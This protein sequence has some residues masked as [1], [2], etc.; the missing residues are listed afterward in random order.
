MQFA[1]SEFFKP[2]NYVGHVLQDEYFGYVV[3]KFKNRS[4]S[5]VIFKRLVEQGKLPAEF[6]CY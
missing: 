5:G 4:D 2:D 1:N 6:V 3:E